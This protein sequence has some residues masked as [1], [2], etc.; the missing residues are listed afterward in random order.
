MR[1]LERIS[2]AVEQLVHGAYHALLED[3]LRRE[4]GK[5]FAE[6]VEDPAIK[7]QMLL[8]GKKPL[9]EALRQAIELQ[10]VLLAA[11]TQKKLAPGR[12]GEGAIAPYRAKRRKTDGVL[13]LWRA[14]P[15]PGYLARREGGRRRPPPETKWKNPDRDRNR[16]Q[17]PNGD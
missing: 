8:E 13:E 10:A 4:M 2:Y 1:I 11:G 16:Q 6:G 17:S 15:L 5:A 7:I 12:S 3:H 14:R 9:N